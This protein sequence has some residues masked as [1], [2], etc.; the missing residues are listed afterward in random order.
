MSPAPTGFEPYDAHVCKRLAR[1]Y[2]EN[3]RFVLTRHTRQRM[4][5]REITTPDIVNTLRA[6]LPQPG[7]LEG[8][9]WRYRFNTM[10]FAV[11]VEFECDELTVV[12]VWRNDR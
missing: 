7:E 10:R 2:T 9:A 11:L 5:E 3:G 6:G 4:A 12:S 8:G 1:E